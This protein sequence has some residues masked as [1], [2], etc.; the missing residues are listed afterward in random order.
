M[1]SIVNGITSLTHLHNPICIPYV[2][3]VVTFVIITTISC[4]L[5]IDIF[6][7]DFRVVFFDL[8]KRE[9]TSEGVSMS[10]NFDG[11]Y[12]M[13]TTRMNPKSTVPTTC[14]ASELVWIPG[15][16]ECIICQRAAQSL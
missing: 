7:T 13:S 11:A 8:T 16:N 4:I 2:D 3:N 6:K 1:N 15:E 9:G 12:K 14:F 10:F 5:Y